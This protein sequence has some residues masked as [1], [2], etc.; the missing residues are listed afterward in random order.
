MSDRSVSVWDGRIN[1]GVTIRGQG[2]AL[3]Y[4]HAAAGPGWDPFLDRLSERHTV[5]A[6]E[7]PGTTPGDPYAIHH[8][9]DLGDAVLIYEEAVRKLGIEGATVIGQSFGGMLS[10][11]LASSFPRLFS[12]LV[13]LDPVGLWDEKV[14]VSNWM[15]APPDTLPSL[16]FKY[17]QSPAAQ[18]MLA[19][20]PD[21]EA[22]ARALAQLT[23]N[24]GATGKM[25][26]PI[27]ERGLHKRLHRISIPTLIVWGEDDALIPVHYAAEFGR[28]IPGSTV[29]IVRDC[30]HVPQV[31]RC[32]E[33]LGLV[34]SFLENVAVAC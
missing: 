13:A 6:P 20:P 9:D 5:Y 11:E 19:L 31:E 4:L 32:D 3:L 1:L 30:G 21:P 26:W 16:L 7:F 12:R 28:R 10:L 34:Q 8:V 2:P 15:A 33:T 25:L 27:P 24:F 22:A 29:R 18:A 17:P 14:P 23:W